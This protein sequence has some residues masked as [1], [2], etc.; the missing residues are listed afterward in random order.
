MKE[1]QIRCEVEV[2]LLNVSKVLWLPQW[3]DVTVYVC[4]NKGTSTRS[5]PSL[6][7]VPS[8]WTRV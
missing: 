4:I 2:W 3:V 8:L 6:L 5:W 1:G 7:L